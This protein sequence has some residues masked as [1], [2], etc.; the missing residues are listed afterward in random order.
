[1]TFATGC[2]EKNPNPQGHYNSAPGWLI[3]FPGRLS[4][5][6]NFGG[7]ISLQKSTEFVSRGVDIAIRIFLLEDEREGAFGFLLP[8]GTIHIAKEGVGGEPSRLIGYA[9]AD[10]GSE[11]VSCPLWIN[12]LR[13]KRKRGRTVST[14]V[15]VP[16]GAALPGICL[17]V[18]EASAG[19]AYRRPSP[20]GANSKPC[21]RPPI[22]V[23]TPLFERLSRTPGIILTLR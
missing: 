8:V 3:G 11:R 7:E 23:D 17:G 22:E 6:L 18:I 2:Q 14:G 1:M 9:V 4:G 13:R 16:I 12:R 5:G 19:E 20:F 15:V 21:S 10:E